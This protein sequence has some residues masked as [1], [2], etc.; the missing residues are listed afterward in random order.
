MMMVFNKN[1]AWPQP[2]SPADYL[3][4]RTLVNRYQAF[5]NVIWD[6]AKEAW[7]VPDTYWAAVFPLV[8][9]L[10]SFIRWCRLLVRSCNL[11]SH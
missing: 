8:E 9:E 7:R 1:V 6:V 5:S 4:W 3:Y 2:L 11:A 10:V